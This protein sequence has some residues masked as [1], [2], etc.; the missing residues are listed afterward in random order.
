MGRRNASLENERL[1]RG[2]ALP[3]SILPGWADLTQAEGWPSAVTLTR[4]DQ[5]PLGG[6][7]RAPHLQA[8]T[9]QLPDGV[10]S[11]AAEQL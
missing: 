5:L 9:E 10:R 3:S 6:C 8:P 4:T 11:C 7:N 1:L 2:L